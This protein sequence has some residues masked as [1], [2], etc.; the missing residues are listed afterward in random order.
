MTA[1][2]RGTG[3][4]RDNRAELSRLNKP[5]WFSNVHKNFNLGSSFA[6]SLAVCLS[7]HQPYH[8]VLQPSQHGPQASP[9]LER[10]VAFD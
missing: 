1:A 6:D 5:F 3:V 4:Q 8:H 10:T 9:A 2:A 7:A